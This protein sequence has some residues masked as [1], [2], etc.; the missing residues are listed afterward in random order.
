MMDARESTLRGLVARDVLAELGGALDARGIVWV[1]LKGAA[2]HATGCRLPAERP[3]EDIDVLVSRKQLEDALA[4]AKSLGFE[5]IAESAAA[6]TLF[7][8]STAL[9]LDLHHRL[10][11]PGLFRLEASD[12][13]GSAV[14][15]EGVW[16]PS[17]LDLYAHLVGHFAKGRLGAMDRRHLGDFA[18]VASH[19]RLEA[20]AVARH[21]EQ[22]GLARAA[23]YT[24]SL[25]RDVEHD[26]FGGMVIAALHA[27]RLGDVM[28]AIARRALSSRRSAL[29][30]SIVV[31]LL[32]E[33][34]PRGV[35]FFVLHGTE[36]V[37][38]RWRAASGR[39]GRRPEGRLEN[40][41]VP[42]PSRATN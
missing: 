4:V 3:L 37:L 10:F 36:S 33:S 7:R 9:P 21:L 18:R 34:I 27:D 11:E 19:L 39:P 41:A 29:V 12:L 38:R 26:V 28:A 24:L 15:R 17:P 25:S 14:E 1:A 42:R 16:T 35:R 22:H 31:S 40:D 23:R 2:L 6:V 32:C 8:R 30:G 13:L 20:T 5:P